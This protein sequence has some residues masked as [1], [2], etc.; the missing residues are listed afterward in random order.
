MERVVL[1]QFNVSPGLAIVPAPFVD[2][3]PGCCKV[4]GEPIDGLVLGFDTPIE[5]LELAFPLSGSHEITR[6]I[7]GECLWNAGTFLDGWK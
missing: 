3:L 7:F 1:L 2:M 6:Y 5:S 4:S